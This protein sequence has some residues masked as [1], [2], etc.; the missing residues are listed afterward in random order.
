MVTIDGANFLPGTTVSFGG[1]AAASVTVGSSTRITAVTPLRA[2]YGSVALSLTS[3]GQTVT[4]A[5]GFSYLNA[6]GSNIQLVGQIG[7]AV[8][9]VAV[10]GNMVYY[11]EGA[12]LVVSDFSDSQH[13]VE[14]GRIALPGIVNDLVVVSNVAFIATGGAGLYA[15]DVTMPSAPAIVGFFDTEGSA[16]GVAVS[17]GL[18][19]VA[20]YGAGLQILDITNPGAIARLGLL[21]T[22]GNVTRVTVGTIASKQY[23]FVAESYGSGAALRVIEVTTPS[24]PVE[25]TNVPLQCASG[26]AIDLKLVG[27]KLYVSDCVV[28]IFDVSNPA[29]LVQTGSYANTGAGGFIDVVGNRLYACDGPMGVAD[30]TVTPNPTRLG[31]FVGVGGYYCYKLVVANNLAFA[32]MDSDGLKVVNVSDP[33]S[34]SLRSA[35]QTLGGVNDVWV[36]GGSAFV[37]N[38]SGLHSLDVSNPAKPARLA[39]LPGDRVTSL[40]VANGKA[41]LV[42]YGDNTVRIANVATPA[43]L[44]PLGIYTN[45]EPWAVALMGTTPVLVGATTDAAHLPKIDVLNISSPSA[46]RSTGSLLLDNAYGDAEAVTVVSNW[47]FVGRANTAL[48][49]VSLAN[50]ASPQKVGSVPITNNVWNVAVSADGNFVYVGDVALGIQ[51][52]DVTVKTMPVLGQVIIPP[53]ATGTV[54]GYVLVVGNRLFATEGGFIFVFDITNPASPQMVGYY[55]IPA[56]GQGIAVDGDLIYVADTY[57]GVSILRLKDVDKPTVAI[58]SPTANTAYSTNAALLTLG[59]VASDDKG[60]VRVTWENDRGGGGVASGT[61]NWQISN[62]QLTAGVNVITVTAEDANG[63]LA[64]DLLTVTANLPDTTPPVVTITGP[65]P[66][67]EF[68]VETNLI[69]LSGSAADNQAVTNVTWSNNRGGSGTIA[70]AGQTWSVTNLLLALGPNLIQVTATDSSGNLAADTAVIFFAPPDT[71]APSIRIEFPTLNVVYETPFGVLDLSGTAADNVGVTEVKWTTSRGGQGVVNGVAPWSVNGI[72]L[73]PGLNIIEVTAADAAGNTA[74]DT[75]VVTYTPPPLRLNAL[76]VS[77]GIFRLELSGPPMTCVIQVTADLVHWLSL[78]TN[79]IPAEGSLIISD[80]GVSNR[81]VRFYR[82]VSL[83]VA[84]AAVLPALSATRL[85]SDLLLSWPTNFTGFTLETAT[86]LPPTSW[87]SNSIPP[88]IVNGQ[89]TVTNAIAG[90]KKFYRLRK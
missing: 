82:A 41:T 38:G 2:S 76:G 86:N 42:Q 62:I 16:R 79:T 3:G 4:Q 50:P 45:V 15:V 51:V 61:T 78:S 56:L 28:K 46:P 22:A 32:A 36:S 29:G 13:P 33:A 63:N 77:N 66:D 85:G 54:W 35:I 9:A 87:T 44:S 58:T 37:G 31:E 20:D 14:R 39:T 5:N 48:D 19:Y 27:T 88:A 10:V 73:Q 84:A 65:K 43:A 60:V 25:R 18:A 17:G 90:G 74:T 30:L 70:L 64:T 52:V 55:D 59:G 67:D 34:M 23:A 6:L 68:A 1:V 80:P 26:S 72:A 81:P 71:N 47:A 7:G 83:A 24:N 12:G 75:L 69:T 57:V 49:V 89:W 11:G 53:L 40:V 21:D 8:L